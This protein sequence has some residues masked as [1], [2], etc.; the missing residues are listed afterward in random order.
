M[1]EL[2]A[3]EPIYRALIDPPKEFPPLVVKALQLE[4]G[5]LLMLTIRSIAMVAPHA[6]LMLEAKPKLQAYAPTYMALV[7][8]P[9]ELSVEEA[10]QL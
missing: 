5:K 4:Q 7:D 9:I 10:M 8:P 3:C 1:V 6:L 2:E